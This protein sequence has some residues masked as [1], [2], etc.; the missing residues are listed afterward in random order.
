MKRLVHRR[1]SKL[2]NE[3]RKHLM[4]LGSMVSF[5]GIV[6]LTILRGPFYSFGEI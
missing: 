2:L 1:V 3:F 5:G 4:F 6:N